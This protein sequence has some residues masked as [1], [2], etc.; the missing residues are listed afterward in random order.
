MENET[1]GYKTRP[2]YEFDTLSWQSI[3]MRFESILS[4]IDF[5]DVIIISQSNRVDLI[6]VGHK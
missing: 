1:E 2:L 5:I 4:S 6:L 3:G